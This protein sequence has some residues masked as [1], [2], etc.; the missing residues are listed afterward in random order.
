MKQA[1]AF[2]ELDIL[3]HEID[4]IK[5]SIHY[6]KEESD[7]KELEQRLENK[8]K[9]FSKVYEVY[10]LSWEARNATPVDERN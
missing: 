3:A 6:S 1:K 4:E 5:E 2:L 8:R 7:T 9:E 10:G